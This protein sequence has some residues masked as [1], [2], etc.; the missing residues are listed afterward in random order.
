VRDAA[1]TV[2]RAVFLALGGVAVLY[3]AVHVTAQGILG[4]AL[5]ADPVT[6]LATAAER[7]LGAPGRTVMLV[8][9]AVSMLGYLGGAM[10]AV[11]R[12]LFALARDGFLPSS[13]AAVHARF[14]TPHVAIVACALVIGALALSGTFERLAVLANVSVLAL[15]F[16][17]AVAAWVLRR[18]D[19]RADGEPFRVPGG[20]WTPVL[21]AGLVLWVLAATTT[22]REIVAVGVAL[23]VALVFMAVRAT[24]RR[25][26]ARAS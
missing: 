11:P 15:Y 26:S 21:A 12:A 4:S 20:S 5:A 10:L 13:L 8:G 2:P 3:L 6:P 16:L 19:V 17:C 1:R 7:I 14:H 25:R 24:S 18:R 9:A 22:R 23:A